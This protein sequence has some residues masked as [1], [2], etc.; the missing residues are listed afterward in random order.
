MPLY[1]YRCLDCQSDF[2]LLIRGDDRPQCPQCAG[3]HLAKQLSAPAAHVG[4]GELPTCQA[5]QS[6]AAPM[7]CGLPQCGMGGCGM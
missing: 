1:E 4:T 5:A 2:E 3:D 7:G 6:L